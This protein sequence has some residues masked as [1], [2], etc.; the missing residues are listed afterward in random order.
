VPSVVIWAVVGK[1]MIS[2]YF[3]KK[4]NELQRLHNATDFTNSDFVARINFFDN[5]SDFLSRS[6]PFLYT[7]LVVIAEQFASG[8]P[9]LSAS[10]LLALE[11]GLAVQTGLG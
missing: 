6:N 8:F 10:V 5:K 3:L 1:A 11:R 7:I 4:M 9:I 2:F